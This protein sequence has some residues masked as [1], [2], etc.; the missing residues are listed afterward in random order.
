[1]KRNGNNGSEGWPGRQRRAWGSVVAAAGLAWAGACG[2]QG[3][4][5]PLYVGNVAPVLDQW[6]RPMAGSDKS[7][8]AA[9]RSRVELRVAPDGIARPP[10]A[11]GS[12]HA[13][14]PL[15]SPESVVGIGLN[16]AQP[17]SGIFAVAF[18]TRPPPG[19]KLFARAF[20]APTAEAASFYSD[21][22]VVAI[23]ER[24]G[25]LVIVFGETRPLDAADDDG[26]GLNNSWEKALGTD[27][28]LRDTDGDGMSDHEEWLAGTDPLDPASALS[29]VAIGRPSGPALL[30]ADGGAGPAVRI[31]WQAVP[32]RTY[33][34]QHAESLVDGGG[35]EDVGEPMAAA[36]GEFEIEAWVEL[37]EDGTAG[38]FRVRLVG[39]EVAP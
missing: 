24:G 13:L 7:A 4:V 11:D 31:R 2:A 10:G 16:A 14:N 1:M 21:S 26:D 28:L 32:G 18:S 8:A 6:G 33:Q 39:G 38:A 20:N 12:A 5:E 23:P 27:P 15:L 22:A 29:F 25:T 36:A 37:P 17:D 34:L 3:F 30:D 9:D 35:F 19:T